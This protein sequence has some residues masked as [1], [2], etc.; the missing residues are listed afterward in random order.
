MLAPPRLGRLLA[1]PTHAAHLLRHLVA[2]LPT[3]PCC[4]L[5]FKRKTDRVE[6]GMQ[7]AMRRYLNNK[8]W[9]ADF[10]AVY[11][12]MMGSSTLSWAARP[13][14]VTGKEC[15]RGGYT[16]QDC[17]RGRVVNCGGCGAIKTGGRF[18]S[19]AQNVASLQEMYTRTLPAGHQANIILS[20]TCCH[21]CSCCSCCWWGK[22]MPQCP[23]SASLS[24]VVPIS[25]W[26]VPPLT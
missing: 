12:K 7:A 11:K 17:P 6:A 23:F 22:L 26:F 19:F 8:V 20:S 2:P 4:L 25:I 10:S 1:V 14:K 24:R 15:P 9:L 16:N 13:L 5:Q 3:L 18:S 21:D